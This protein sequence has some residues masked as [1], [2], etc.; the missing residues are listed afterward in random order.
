MPT[1]QSL[2]WAHCTQACK[3]WGD[4]NE[5]MAFWI[6]LCVVWFEKCVSQVLTIPL[7]CF[8]HCRKIRQALTKAMI[9]WRFWG[10]WLLCRGTLPTCKWSYREERWCFDIQLLGFIC[11]HQLQ[12][13]SFHNFNLKKAFIIFHLVLHFFRSYTTFPFHPCFLMKT[14]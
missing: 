12:C 9:W 4:A 3:N 14:L 10:N 13:Q 8:S 2:H 6:L 11:L 1:I 5:Q 7:R